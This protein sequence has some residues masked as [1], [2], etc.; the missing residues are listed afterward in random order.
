[1][2]HYTRVN[3]VSPVGQ[4]KIHR[5]ETFVFEKYCDLEISAFENYHELDTW[6]RK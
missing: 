2:A 4:Y 3:E 5:F 1:M 6:I